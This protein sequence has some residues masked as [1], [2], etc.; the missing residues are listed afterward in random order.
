MPEQDNFG[1]TVLYSN[2]GSAV[3][4]PLF[5][6]IYS[7]S[8]SFFPHFSS[9]VSRQSFRV[10]FSVCVYEI[11]RLYMHIQSY[12][13]VLISFSPEKCGDGSGSEPSEWMKWVLSLSLSLRPSQ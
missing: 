12:P 10:F 2:P 1:T 7:S 8:Y 5:S 9:S 6:I 4:L 11:V 13:Y 3:L